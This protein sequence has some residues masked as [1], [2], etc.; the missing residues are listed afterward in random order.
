MSTDSTL[1][2]DCLTISSRMAISC[3]AA[4]PSNECRFRIDRQI[5]HWSR[6]RTRSNEAPGITPFR[7]EIACRSNSAYMVHGFAEGAARIR[8]SRFVSIQIR[9]P[10]AFDIR[11]HLGAGSRTAPQPLRMT[12][13]KRKARSY[14]KRA[15]PHQRCRRPVPRLPL[16]R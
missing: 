12:R 8:I 5:I 16:F 10:W 7:R 14:Q 6:P 4:N 13:V 3:D 9:F 11:A 1:R 2:S 15:G